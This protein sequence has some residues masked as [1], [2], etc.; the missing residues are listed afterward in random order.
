MRLKVFQAKTMAAAI[1]EIRHLLGDDAII[2][3]SETTA[4]GV[5]ITAAIDSSE[6][7][8]TALSLKTPDVAEMLYDLLSYHR[9][10]LSIA[11]NLI[12]MA[13]TLD[14]QDPVLALGS[15]F[16]S[17]LSFRPLHP[18][19]SPQRILLIGPFGEG[20]TVT[21]ARLAGRAMLAE[22]PV[23]VIAADSGRA[24][25]VA[26][27]NELCR[28]MNLIPRI[29]TSDVLN[30]A[31]DGL[32]II[33]GPGVNPLN[34]SD[35]VEIEKLINATGAEP[36]LVIAAGT[37]PEEATQ[38]GETF[39]ALGV[40]RFIATRI[41]TTRQLGSIL[42]TAATGLSCADAG[43][44]RTLINTLIPMNPLALARLLAAARLGTHSFGSLN[45]EE[46]A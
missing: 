29:L 10:P 19:K 15:A 4:D 20:K 17:A 26:Q 31:D 33:D 35:R 1:A 42:T 14:T 22:C 23:R 24:G 9:V 39:S 38:I 28:P 5:R 25:A 40:E 46:A 41:D 6:Q 44:G 32:T 11:E 27:I 13:L 34:V 36:I 45:H 12:G 3:G 7:A 37:E 18:T 8:P 16:D 21:A 2:I 43:I 30:D